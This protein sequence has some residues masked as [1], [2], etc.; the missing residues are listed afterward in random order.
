MIGGHP[1]TRRLQGRAL[2]RR[3]SSTTPRP[4]SPATSTASCPA[5]S[6]MPVF[7]PRGVLHG[8]DGVRQG[9]ETLL[10]DLPDAAAPTHIFGDDV[11][12]IEWG[13]ASEKTKALDGVDTFVFA[14]GKITVQTVRN[15]V[16]PTQG[17]RWR[18][19]PGPWSATTSARASETP[20]TG[21][22]PRATRTFGRP[23]WSCAPRTT[24]VPGEVCR[25]LAVRSCDRMDRSQPFWR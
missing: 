22:G 5:T 1:L 6:P 7:I 10:S 4:W 20:S 3:S 23:G 13:A 21:H 19:R 16:E 17:R 24:S 14:D 8:K 25:V 2:R 15:T 11:L 18:R 12:F 9:F